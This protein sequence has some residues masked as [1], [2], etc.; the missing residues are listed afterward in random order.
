[1]TILWLVECAG[2]HAGTDT[3]TVGV[4][5]VLADLA[6]GSP[7][8]T[9]R[10]RRQRAERSTVHSYATYPPARKHPHLPL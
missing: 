9:T 2:R 8:E 5:A 7:N 1:M 3:K 10:V 4:G 6:N